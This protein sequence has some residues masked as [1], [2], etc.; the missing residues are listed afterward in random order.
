MQTFSLSVRGAKSA[1]RKAMKKLHLEV[2]RMT[3]IIMG[4]L[5]ERKSEHKA[6][7]GSLRFFL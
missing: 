3:A 2:G 7:L 1:Y 4:S 5:G 6:D